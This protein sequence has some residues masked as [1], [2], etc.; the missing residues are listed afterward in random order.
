MQPAFSG[1]RHHLRIVG[2]LGQPGRAPANHD[3][4]RFTRHGPR[5]MDNVFVGDKGLLVAG[6]C[7]PPDA[8]VQPL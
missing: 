6:T 2:N 1:E 7:N 4:Q 8:S 5:T 3:T